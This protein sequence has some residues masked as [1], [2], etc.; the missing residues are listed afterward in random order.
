MSATSAYSV[1]KEYDFAAESVDLIFPNSLDEM[2]LLYKWRWEKIS[3][4][5]SFRL[6]IWDD[7]SHMVTF[8][9]EFLALEVI[10]FIPLFNQNQAKSIATCR[11]N[12]Q[13]FEQYLK[14][15]KEVLSENNNG[16]SPETE[17][18]IKLFKVFNRE[19]DCH[20]PQVYVSTESVFSSVD[21]KVDSQGKYYFLQANGTKRYFRLCELTLQTSRYPGLAFIAPA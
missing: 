15:E 12:T 13:V 6:L 7:D 16:F 11:G 18:V 5:T 19:V 17:A 20:P 4:K 8:D 14:L 21:I 3:A 1:E 9:H 2:A 10:N